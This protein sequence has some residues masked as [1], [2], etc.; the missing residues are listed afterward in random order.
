M[1]HPGLT[2]LNARTIVPSAVPARLSASSTGYPALIAAMEAAGA[3]GTT[4]NSP[5]TPSNT[6]LEA[7]GTLAMARGMAVPCDETPSRSCL[8][9]PHRA[10]GMPARLCAFVKALFG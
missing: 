5:P 10:R 4:F 6:A 3:A 7:L 1:T 8:I 2:T 9:G